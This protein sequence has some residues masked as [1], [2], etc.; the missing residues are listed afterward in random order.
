MNVTRFARQLTAS[1]PFRGLIIGAI[2][3]A[4]VVAG[5][6]TNAPLMAEHGA[7]LRRLDGV[8]I[9][10]FVVEIALKL[11]APHR[12]SRR[13]RKKTVGCGKGDANSEPNARALAGAL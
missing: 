9:A 3:L 10:I 12:W 2:L 7:W 1:R 6:E 5:V 11:L 4:G 13:R 8:I